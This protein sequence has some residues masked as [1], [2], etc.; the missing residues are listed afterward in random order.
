[1]KNLET[2]KKVLTQK[3]IEAI[4][5]V[6]EG[7]KLFLDSYDFRPG[8]KPN[9]ESQLPRS[10]SRAPQSEGNSSAGTTSEGGPQV[11]EFSNPY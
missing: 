1:M 6:F 2:D 8:V 9:P 3:E 11:L 4:T 7:L 5:G 10:E